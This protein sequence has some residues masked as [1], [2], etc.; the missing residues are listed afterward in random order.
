MKCE[1]SRTN[2]GCA[3][4]CVGGVACAG[5]VA[6]EED[7][8]AQAA[9][10]GGAV[11]CKASGSDV[12]RRLASVE[13]VVGV[14]VHATPLWLRWCASCGRAC[15]RHAGASEVAGVWSG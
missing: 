6:N 5:V 15:G 11:G 1:I 10:G 3:R 7:E 9:R 2:P 8:G 14:V 13:R 12:V 4:A